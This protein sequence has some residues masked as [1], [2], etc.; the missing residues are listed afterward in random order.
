MQLTSPEYFILLALVFFAY[1]FARRT[2]KLAVAIILGA[3]YFFYARWHPIY[4]GLIPLAATCD[5]FIGRALGV[6]KSRFLITLSILLN[7][8]LILTSRYVPFLLDPFA[9]A[10]PAV[11]SWEWLLPLSLSFYA[12]QAMTW[13]I[14]IY[15][16]DATPTPSLLSYLA[17]VSFF[18]TIVAGPITR[19]ARLL[20]QIEDTSLRLT[21]E[22]GS[23]ALFLIGLGLVKKLLIADYL[24]ENLVNRVFDL[25]KLY[26]GM[27]TLLGAYGYTFQLYYDFSGYTDIA[28]GSALLL[29]ITLPANFNRPYAALNVADFWRRWHISLSTWLRDYLFFSLPGQRSRWRPY[30]N[31][32]ITFTLGGLWHGANWT[33][34]VWGAL[35][36]TGLAVVRGLQA[37]RGKRKPQ[38]GV[39]L[40]VLYI[41]VTFHFVALTWIFFRSANLSTA[42]DVLRQI[43]SG[44]VSLANVTPGFWMVLG[45][46]VA[47]HYVPHSWYTA[48]LN[49]FT[50]VPAPVQAAALALLIAGI[51]YV[52]VTGSAPFIYSRF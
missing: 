19:V 21:P 7:C 27:E 48:S 3:N 8:G 5:F 4:L 25:P 38:P 28:L 14:D 39:V 12:F 9:A 44:T 29:G 46:A 11:A 1:W 22:D 36:G 26:S 33:F 32:F 6:R 51:R 52:A 2:G 16:G 41:V 20:P 50:R 34:V 45:I 31:L 15:R 24:G 17:S 10:H 43:D 49:A 40:R 35:H 23:R 13:T 30:L 37:M 42:L 18:P 47:A